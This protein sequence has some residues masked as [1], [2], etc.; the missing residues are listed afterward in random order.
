MDNP[1]SQNDRIKYQTQITMRGLSANLTVDTIKHAFNRHLHFTVVKGRE[2]ATLRDFFFATAFTIRDNI[3]TK[4]IRSQQLYYQKDVKRVYYLSME[5]Y[6]G[7]SLS[8][9]MLNISITSAVEE[10]LY[11]LGLDME[12]LEEIEEDAGLGNGG[13]GRLAACFLDS[14][15]C[16]GYA[17]YGYGL[18]YEYG[19]FKQKIENGYQ[20]EEADDW[21][22]YGNPWEKARPEYMLP[23]NF[24]GETVEEDGKRK[25][26]NTQVVYAMA[27]DTPVP[28]YKNNTV[29]NL[30]LWSAKAPKNFDFSFFH[31]GDYIKAVCDRMHAENITRVLYPNDNIMRGKELRIKQEYFLCSATLQDILRRYKIDKFGNVDV[32]KKSLD[33]FPDKVAIQL[34]DSHPV[35]A[36]PELMRILMDDEHFGWDTAWDITVRTFSFT[37][38]TLVA[39]ALESWS[40]EQIRNLLPR[41]LEI[42]YEINKRH[43]QAIRKKYP[44]DVDKV[45][46]MSIIQGEPD[47]KINMTH[48]GIV[49][50]H[51]VNG[52]SKLHTKLIVETT[53]HDFYLDNPNKFQN[54]TNGISP[55]RWLLLCNPL[56]SDLIT[57]II[58]DDW[59]S[60]LTKLSALK[61][62]ANDDKIVMDFYKVK[63]ENKTKFSD[64]IHKEYKI[65]LNP[66]ALFDVQVKRI[67]EYKRQLLNLFYVITLYNRIKK[68]PED[69]FPPRVS[70]IGGKASPGYQEAKMIV[71]LINNVADVINNDQVVHDRLKLIFLENYRVSLAEK[72]IP[73]SD[74]S[75]QISLAGTEASGTGNM[76]FML[77]GAL[78]IG[79]LDGANVEIDEE[80][81]RENIF[82]F[83]MALDEVIKLRNNGYKPIEHYQRNVELRTVIDQIGSGYFS[84]GD[85][86]LFSS[87]V[88]SLM[89]EDKFMIL[90][91]YADYCKRQ[92]DVTELYKD[93]RRWSRKCLMNIASA[94]RFSSDRS[95]TEYAEDI[96][97]VKPLKEFDFYQSTFGSAEPSSDTDMNYF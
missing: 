7:R 43:L 66:L 49:G 44:N 82:I 29:N 35:I 52:V 16:L 78:T 55:R 4:W 40:V 36:I 39:D 38:H 75:E 8:N 94:G 85:S 15:S 5:W 95:I 56:L 59:T 47:S 96:W 27:Y 74:L 22:R 65:K 18:R 77:N 14:L 2:L 60:D 20:V 48:L 63:Q 73:A 54:K 84:A 51:T 37:N 58:G 33:C 88:D 31:H 45:R 76:K 80:V 83:G 50:S 97:N 92:T 69:Y 11:Q 25:W 81:G 13:L 23:V 3:C 87:L 64:F 42:I 19:L 79:T 93:T 10:A 53:F 24:Y 62:F 41:H 67:H 72:I 1:A 90:A 9:T 57:T 6:L 91:D 70:F 46:R 32:V 71:K 61:A 34:N 28:G 68:S 17:G 30:R 12:E 86:G 89:H 26:I 21:L